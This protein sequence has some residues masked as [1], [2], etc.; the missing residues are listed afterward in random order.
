MDYSALTPYTI[1]QGHV[2]IRNSFLQYERPAQAEFVRSPE[3]TLQNYSSK[4]FNTRTGPKK[5]VFDIQRLSLTHKREEMQYFDSL[6]GNEK[7]VY[8]FDFFA[9]LIPINNQGLAE[10]PYTISMDR[11]LVLTPDYSVAERE[12][13]QFEFLEKAI[14]DLD[15]AVTDIVTRMNN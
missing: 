2:E 1:K 4:R 13:R 11:Q 7:D 10:Q 3:V 9:A 6:F 5:M 8:N 15:R 14:S 12:F